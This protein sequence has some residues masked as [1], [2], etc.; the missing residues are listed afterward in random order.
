MVI[1][2]CGKLDHRVFEA[3]RL[4]TVMWA[5]FYERRMWMLCVV[6]TRHFPIRFLELIVDR[7]NKTNFWSWSSGA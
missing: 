7:E 6:E 5:Y 2:I 3:A 4:E 1:L